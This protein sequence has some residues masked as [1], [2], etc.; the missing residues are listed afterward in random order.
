MEKIWKNTIPQSVICSEKQ[1]KPLMLA[2]FVTKAIQRNMGSVTC[3]FLPHSE[4][5]EIPTAHKKKPTERP[6]VKL[7][8]H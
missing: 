3:T 4:L 7:I 2:G 8:T 1:K 5:L 6:K